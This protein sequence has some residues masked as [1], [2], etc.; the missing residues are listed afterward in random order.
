MLTGV[1]A[2]LV[3]EKKE[4]IHGWYVAYPLLVWDIGREPKALNHVVRAAAVH[5]S[6]TLSFILGLKHIWGNV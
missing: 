5:G 3:D 1:T 4:T 2:L 6:I